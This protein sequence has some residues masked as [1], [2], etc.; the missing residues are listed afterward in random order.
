MQVDSFRQE[1]LLGSDRC[2]VN[3][4]CAA[5]K[6][7]ARSL[8]TK[9][10][11]GLLM[12]S[13]ACAIRSVSEVFFNETF[14]VRVEKGVSL[15]TAEDGSPSKKAEDKPCE[16]LDHSISVDK[17]IADLENRLMEIDKML[18]NNDNYQSPFSDV[19]VD[20][21]TTCKL[22]AS[23]LKLRV[24]SAKEAFVKAY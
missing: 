23:K 3:F 22:E 12:S 19:T 2:V 7:N 17:L 13:M 24:S 10:E 8:S 20:V 18:E 21:N 15:Q 9:D 14:I 4:G 1:F 16:D 11:P 6:Y 5:I